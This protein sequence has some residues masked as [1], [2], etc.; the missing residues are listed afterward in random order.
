[1]CD[2]RK[3]R[4]VSGG[5]L[6]VVRAP[7]HHAGLGV[8]P[9]VDVLVLPADLLQLAPAQRRR[10]QLRLPG[11]QLHR[12]PLLLHVQHRYVLQQRCPGTGCGRR[13]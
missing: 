6:R 13:C 2:N 12:P 11:A 1:M 7:E 9:G 4:C 10:L 3:R 8:L 5:A